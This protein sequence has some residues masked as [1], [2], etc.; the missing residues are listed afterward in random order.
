M[1]SD[2][3][4][5]ESLHEQEYSSVNPRGDSGS[6]VN[7]R[8]AV[9]SDLNA[10]NEIYNYYV[11][12]ST[13]TYQEQPE[14]FSDRHKWFYDHDREYPVVV[15][16][17]NGEVVSWGSISR[18][19]R[20]TAYRYTVENSIYVRH[21]WHRRGIGSL[22]LQEI[23]RRSRDLGYRT[24][25]AAIDSDQTQSISLH[26]KFNFQHVGRLQSVGWKFGR[27]LDVIYMELLLR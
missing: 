12:N 1:D 6:N 14:T 2:S 8:P 25:I 7:L 4:S 27:W 11:L 17:N 22:L 13:C 5:T 15:A 10:I 23:I 21:D 3:D 26:A 18:Y 19:R 20:R 24:I 9:G 16:E